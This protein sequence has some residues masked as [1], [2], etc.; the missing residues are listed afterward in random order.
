MLLEFKACGF[1][2][3]VPGKFKLK[4]RNPARE[5]ELVLAIH[6]LQS[7]TVVN[8]SIVTGTLM[9]ALE[10]MS[11]VYSQLSKISNSH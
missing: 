5:L 3:M 1:E 10:L 8:F 11:F 2:W 9:L 7:A 6:K 4:L